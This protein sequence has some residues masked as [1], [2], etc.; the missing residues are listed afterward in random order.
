MRGVIQKYIDEHPD[1]IPDLEKRGLKDMEVEP[2]LPVP[3][4]EVHPFQAVN[5]AE[6]N[7][8]SIVYCSGLGLDFSR[9]IPD[10][11][12]LFDPKSGYPIQTD[13]ASDHHPGLFFL[14][15]HWMRK[16]KSAILLGCADDALSVASQVEQ[17]RHRIKG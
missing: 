6:H 11:P 2:I 5:L 7:I 4:C 1:E 15:L 3:D 10:I 13:G 16:W 17:R 8:T 12:D 9:L 14:G